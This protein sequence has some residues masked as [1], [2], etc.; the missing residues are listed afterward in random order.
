MSDEAVRDLARRAGIAVEWTD[1][2][3][4]TKTAKPDV[5][6]TILA[7]LGVPCGTRGDLLASRR[8]LLRKP[9]VHALAPLLTATAGRPSRLDIGANQPRSASLILESGEMREIT[10]APVRG[11]LRL[12]A[13]N[14]TGYHRLRVDNREFVL[15]VAPS[16]CHTINDAVPDGRLWGIA[17]Q[18]HALRRRGDGGVGDAGAV[19]ML[20]EAAGTRGADALALSPLHAPFGASPARNGPY[21]PST[22]LFLNPLYASPAL[23]FGEASVNTVIHA[24]GLGELFERMED[25]PIIDWP[26]VAGGK[27]RL[28]RALFEAFVDTPGH[29]GPLGADFAQFRAEGGTPLMQHAVFEALHTIQSAKGESDWRRWPLDLRDPCSAA[30][31]VFAAAH[32]REVLFHCFL[33]WLADRSIAIAQRRAREAGMRIGL[34]GDLAVGVDPSG[35]QAWSR[36]S[37]V[38]G[39]L[40]IGCP[41]DLFNPRGQ[42]W[43]L[44]GFSPRALTR[45][46]FAPFLATVRAALRH[47]GGLRIGH[48]MGLTRLWLIPQGGDPGEGVYLA[49]PLTDLL[50]LL[51]LES[52]RHRA[53]VLGEDLGIVPNGFREALELAGLHGTRVLW[54]ERNGHAFSAPGAWDHSAVAMTSTHDLPT[55]AGWWHA[56]DVVTRSTAGGVDVGATEDE[57]AHRAIER[58]ALWDAFVAHGAGEGAPPAQNDTQPVVDAALA[59]VATTPSPLCLP[60]IE[61]LIGIAEQRNLPRANEQHSRWRRRLTSPVDSLLD[62]PATAARVA[63]LTTAR[64]RL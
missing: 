14:E 59:F 12:P 18:V 28:L 26:A 4:R 15:A 45:S 5:L 17:A 24:E 34:I 2:T 30:V 60:T 49:Y 63:R 56:N 58:H 36:Q 37:D 51:A 48:A 8:C 50:R 20:A 9:T 33:Q 13:I 38:L 40:S 52:H 54:F 55:I 44:T 42:N 23:V 16:R 25:Q 21:S 29:E 27:F 35:S 11:R 19:A 1:F 31:R 22:R 43:G 46:G 6:R 41:P 32:R 39:G 47:T 61:D 64:P 57:G 7:S 53:I 62:E 10:L 3:G